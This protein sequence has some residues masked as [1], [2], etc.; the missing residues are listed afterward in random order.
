MTDY[1]AGKQKRLGQDVW[2]MVSPRLA[3]VKNA[4]KGP[5]YKVN[6]REV[7]EDET[8]RYWGWHD[9]EKDQYESIMSSKLCVVGSFQYG[10]QAMIKREKSGK[11]ELV[12]LVIEEIEK[13]EYE[14]KT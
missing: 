1:Y 13:I 9:F 5:H 7:R 3:F 8:S 14:I 11:G 10:L 2:T 12:N 4:V 6:V